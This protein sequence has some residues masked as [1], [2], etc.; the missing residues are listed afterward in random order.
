MFSLYCVVFLGIS[1]IGIRFFENNNVKSVTVFV[2]I[3]VLALRV[4]SEND[5]Q[6]P[7]G[8]PQSGL[9]FYYY[10]GIYRDVTLTITNKVYI[11][12]ALEAN[13][14][15]RGGVFVTY[16]KVNKDKAEVKIKTHVVN[17]STY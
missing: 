13:K 9:D 11:S 8:K 7:P 6:T 4:S 12:D 2:C 3:N 17:Q 16:P 5:P 10:G 15:A 14:I 1:Y